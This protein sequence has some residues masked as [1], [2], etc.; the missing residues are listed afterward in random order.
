[1][2]IFFI[3]KIFLIVQFFQSFLLVSGFFFSLPRFLF[4]S[5]YI[6]KNQ[7]D[8]FSGFWLMLVWQCYSGLE[9]DILVKVSGINDHTYQTEAFFTPWMS[10]YLEVYWP[11]GQGMYPMMH[12]FAYRK[13]ENAMDQTGIW[14]STPWIYSEV[15]IWLNYLAP[16][17]VSI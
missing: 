6:F 12:I 7:T 14:T 4:L 5:T 8:Q 13:G 11:I 10:S 17:I 15:L 1:M 9:S 3:Y 2:V 16:V